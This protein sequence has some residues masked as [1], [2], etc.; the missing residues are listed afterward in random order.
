M[1]KDKLKE[2]LNNKKSLKEDEKRKTILELNK[3]DYSWLSKAKIKR[4]SKKVKRLSRSWY[5]D[6]FLF[7]F[8]AF[9]GLFSAYPLIYTICNAFKPLDELFRF[10]PTL[11]PRNVTLNN[12]VDLFN[13][14]GNSQIPVS[15]FIY[16]TLFITLMG[17][18]GHVILAS[19]CAYPLAKYQ[20]P[21]KT[22]IFTLIV[23]SLMFSSAVTGIPNYLIISKL[24]LVDTQ[25]AVIIPAI[26]YTLG[27]YLM[28]QFMESVP[29]E[30]IEAAKIDGA[31]E[32]RVFWSV[33]MPYVKPAWLTLIILLFQQL[34]GTDG[35][36]YIY[37]DKLKPLSYALSQIVSGGISRTGAAS[38]VSVVMLIVPITVFVIN[39]TKVI[40]T[41]A[42][43]G[44]K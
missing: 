37:T 40:N 1:K 4:K 36:T 38:A 2:E 20:F 27:L 24:G 35:G 41:M 34:W 25:W 31:S 30:I 29:M 6:L 19:M 5:G 3:D 17:T 7:L 13:L 10:P 22:I 18:V 21:G 23:Y 33:V 28:K 32:F 42:Y 8:L 11:F 43:S 26:G 39:Q 16:N 9:F 14:I 12:F 15:R 44:I